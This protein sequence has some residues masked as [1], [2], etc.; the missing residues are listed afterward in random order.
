MEV[1]PGSG[2]PSIEGPSPRNFEGS[3]NSPHVETVSSGDDDLEIRLSRKRKPETIVCVDRPAPKG[4]SIRSRLRSANKSIISASF[5]DYVRD[6]YCGWQRFFVQE[7]ENPPVL[8]KTLV[9]VPTSSAPLLLK[10]KGCEKGANPV[11]VIG[12]VGTC[13]GPWLKF[14]LL[15]P[16]YS[17][18][19]L[20][21][22]DYFWKKEI[23]L[24]CVYRDIGYQAGLKDGYACST[25]GLER[26]KIPKYDSKVK[27]QL[28]KLQKEFEGK[29]PIIL[30]QLSSNPTMSLQEHKSL[31]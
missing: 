30:E 23:Y 31:L 5:E 29:S 18:E 17:V 3:H 25:Q 16:I 11:P 12:N 1:V 8:F 28:A 9:S 4:R 15:S 6:T 22:D 27:N 10:G 21:L 19:L 7:F 24:L 13:Q 2:T 14:N 20:M 26:K